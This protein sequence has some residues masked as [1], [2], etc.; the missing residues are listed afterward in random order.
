MATKEP[1]RLALRKLWSDHVIWTREYIVA[2]SPGTPD[3]D[4]AAGTAAQEPG[5]HRSRGGR[6][7][8]GC[9][10]RPLTDLLKEHILIAVDL[11]AAAKAGDDAAFAT[12]D[13]RW[14]KN[15][16]TDRRLPRRS[17]P[18]LARKGC[19][20]SAGVAPQLTK[21]EAVARLSAT[22]PRTSGPS[23]TSS[24]RSWSWPMPCTT[25]SSPSSRSA[26]E[27]RMTGIGVVEAG[28]APRRPCPIGATAPAFEGL[29][30]TDGQRY[31]FSNLADRD[32][33][34][35]IF[36]SNRCPTAKAYADRMNALQRDFGARGGPGPG[37][38]CQRPAPVP[39]ESYPP[40]GRTRRGGRLLVPV[41]LRRRPTNGPSLWADVHLPRLRVG[42]R[43][44]ACATRVDSTI[45]GFRRT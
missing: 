29:L 12:Q 35:L 2:V 19:P 3:A 13:A 20:R 39:R 18:Q 28:P 16:E 5:G 15:I 32:L 6:L 37:D 31:G 11:V 26:L 45:P 23:T 17:Q 10:R 9:R 8:R 36:S 14:T 34:V 33:L 24:P 44:G 40:H 1:V 27:R 41:R 38:Q 25:G 7:L 43:A 30:G 4:A 21:D 42:P 22:G